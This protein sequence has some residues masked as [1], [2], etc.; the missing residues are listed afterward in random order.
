[1][2]KLCINKRSE[3]K[4]AAKF[5]AK[6]TENVAEL[7]RI[8]YEMNDKPAKEKNAQKTT[9]MKICYFVENHIK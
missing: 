5:I 7:L 2:V 9:G 3:T 6:R 8:S 1:M 4:Y